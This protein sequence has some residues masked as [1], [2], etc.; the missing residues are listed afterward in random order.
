[1]E[2]LEIECNRVSNRTAIHICSEH[3]A[4]Q[5]RAFNYQNETRTLIQLANFAPVMRLL[6]AGTE[7][8][9]NIINPPEPNAKEIWYQH[10]QEERDEQM[11]IFGDL[12]ADDELVRS[13]VGNEEQQLEILMLLKFGLENHS[14]VLTAAELDVM[15]AAYDTVVRLSDTIV[16]EVPE[17][18]AVSGQNWDYSAV[19]FLSRGEEECIRT[20]SLWSELNHPNVRKFF[21]A[22]PVGEMPFLIHEHA[23]FFLDDDLMGV[24]GLLWG[25]VLGIA[26]GLEY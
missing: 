24:M 14:D 2:H 13:E 21:G 22:C 10:L 17:W 23:M 9:L 15:S 18:F 19:T 25:S 11:Q 20:A 16:V 1:M 26:R 6:Q 8:A 5:L 7:S 3:V 12:L 4:N